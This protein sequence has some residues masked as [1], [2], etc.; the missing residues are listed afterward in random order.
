MRVHSLEK[1]EQIKKLRREGHSIEEL[2]RAL[3]IPKTTIWHHIQGIK[4]SKKYILKL[5]ANQGGSRLKK[6]RDTIRAQE[7]AKILLSGANGMIYAT[8][9]ALYWAE[10]SKR[11][12]ELVNTDDRMIRLYLKIIREHLKVPE[13]QIQPVLRIFSNHNTKDSLKFW[14]KT[15]KIPRK[16]FKVF[17]NDGGTSGRT[18]YG[19]CRIVI[20]KGGYQLKLFKALA[21][22]LCKNNI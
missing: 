20:L 6:E 16:K 1:I 9:S 2:V 13:S 4:L 18:P 21:T 3:S 14:S 22:E 5:K 19:M 11:R 10:G 17:L 7:E 12:C 8:L 15:T